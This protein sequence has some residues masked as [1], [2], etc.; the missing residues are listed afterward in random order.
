MKNVSNKRLSSFHVWEMSKHP[1]MLVNHQQHDDFI[2]DRRNDMDLNEVM[3]KR[4]I[5]QQEKQWY[6]LDEEFPWDLSALRQEVFACM[7]NNFHIPVV[8]CDPC[9]A[10]KIVS[11]LG[12]EETEHLQFA[13][14]V[15]W[16]EV[17]IVFIFHFEEYLSLMETIFHEL[18]HVMQE[19]I[20]ELRSHFEWDKHIPYEQRVTE[21]DAFHYAKIYLDKYLQQTCFIV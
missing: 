13:S 19:D 6:V 12:E 15:Y 10:N 20:P 9:E 11:E 21:Q 7:E 4:N 8:F 14:G 18:R 1:K 16:R 3:R 2:E 5:Y 17:G